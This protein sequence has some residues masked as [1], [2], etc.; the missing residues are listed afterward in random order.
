MSSIVGTNC[1]ARAGCL[2]S[3]HLSRCL[4]LI[5]LILG[6]NEFPAL[7]AAGGG[8]GGGVPVCACL[9]F[10]VAGEEVGGGRGG[11]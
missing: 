10:G 5:D 9:E 6:R 7:R 2:S 8:G 3:G 11:C 4:A 1:S